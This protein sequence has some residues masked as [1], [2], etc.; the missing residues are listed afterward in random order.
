[1]NQASTLQTM[2]DKPTA[3]RERNALSLPERLHELSASPAARGA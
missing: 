2:M 3:G 1:M